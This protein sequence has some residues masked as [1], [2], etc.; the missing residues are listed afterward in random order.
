MICGVSGSLS[1][2]PEESLFSASAKSISIVFIAVSGLSV[3]SSAPECITA[4]DPAEIST[5][6][7]KTGSGIAPNAN[8][9]DKRIEESLKRYLLL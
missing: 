2:I 1:E 6:S 4:P 7:A 8:M 3:S 9:T 5:V